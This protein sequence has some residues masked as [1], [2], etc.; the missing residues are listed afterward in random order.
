MAEDG[1]TPDPFLSAARFLSP[2]LSTSLSPDFIPTL[3]LAFQIPTFA[4]YQPACACILIPRVPFLLRVSP[5]FLQHRNETEAQI[6]ITDLYID[7]SSPAAMPS[8][9]IHHRHVC[10]VGSDVAILCLSEWFCPSGDASRPENLFLL[11]RRQKEKEKDGLEPA[12]KCH[13][14]G[15]Q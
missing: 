12:T 7:S 1:Y 2:S 6:P 14:T 13:L 8:L 11:R 5:L 3:A 15:G 9:F 4:F 10:G